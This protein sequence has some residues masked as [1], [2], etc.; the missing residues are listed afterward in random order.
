MPVHKPYEGTWTDNDKIFARTTGTWGTHTPVINSS[1]CCK[2]GW[3][4]LYCPTGSM[5]DKGRYVATD[6]KYCKG[7]GVCARECPVNAIV[8]V[9]RED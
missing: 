8:M 2:C 7:C 5:V 9:R 4:S 3:C 6:L 1:K